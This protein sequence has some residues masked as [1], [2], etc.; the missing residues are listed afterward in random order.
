M[1][2]LT[3]FVYETYQLTKNMNESQTTENY[4][5]SFEVS[6]PSFSPTVTL[7]ANLI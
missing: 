1:H 5:S 7:F 2:I 6:N 3:M 4:H